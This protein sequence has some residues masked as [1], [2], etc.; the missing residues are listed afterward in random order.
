M[1]SASA[2]TLLTW[3]GGAAELEA[4]L[5]ALQA[6][7]PQPRTGAVTDHSAIGRVFKLTGMSAAE[8]K[9]MS[10]SVSQAETGALWDDDAAWR[11]YDRAVYRARDARRRTKGLDS[12]DGSEYSHGS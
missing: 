6:A 3:R 5:R 4:R 1:Q 9:G 2:K 8:V 11:K 12:E 10:S 7:A